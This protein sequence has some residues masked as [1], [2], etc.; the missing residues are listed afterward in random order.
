MSDV[1][2]SLDHCIDSYFSPRL[3]LFKSLL[4]ERVIDALLHMPSY[5]IEKYYLTELS[6][7][8]IN[9]IVTINFT[10]DCVEL[11][12]SRTTLPAQIYGRCG[13]QCVEIV[14]FNYKKSYVKSIYPIGK[15]VCISGKLQVSGRGIFKFVNPEKV[16]ISRMNNF[17]GIFNIYP[18]SNGISQ[19]NIHSVMKSALKILEQH[20]LIEWLPW[21]VMNQNAFSSF[22]DS[23]KNIHFPTEIYNHNIENPFYKRLV[24]DELLSEQLVLRLTSSKSKLGNIIKND[25]TLINELR[26]QLPFSLTNAQENALRE[27]LLDM[28]KEHPMTRLLQGDVGSGKTIVAIMAILYAIE[29]GYQCAVLA[30]T[31]ILARQHY[32]NIKK[33]FD[34]L[35]L[36]VDILT[37]SEKGKIRTQILNNVKLG[38]TNVLVGTHAI[39]TDKVTFFNLGLVVIDEQHRFGVN[40]RLDLIKKGRSPHVLSMTATPIPRT[41][42]MSLYGDIE[43][44]A[45][46][47]K[48]KGRKEIITRTISKSRI[49]DIIDSI[50]N[51]IQ[52]DQRVYWICPLVE[53]SEKLKYTCVVNRFEYLK[54][55]FPEN[56]LML[57]GKMKSK[58]KQEIFSKFQT[59]ECKILVSTTV[60]EVGVDVP[61][62]TTIIIENAE[63]FGLAQLHQLRGRV[64]RSDLQSY[65]ILLFEDKISKIATERLKIIRNSNDGFEIAEK[66]LQL[67]GGGEIIGVRQSGEKVYKTFD[68]KD[69]AIQS[70]LYQLLKQASALATYVIDHNQ[71]SNFKTL[72]KI[73][74]PNDF[75]NIKLSF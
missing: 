45:I 13:A 17:K 28:E 4:G 64:G 20:Q 11:N 46:T 12:Q 21:D 30:P 74:K 52:N 34:N 32:H 16:V 54:K 62:A 58:E 48:P 66:D 26:V 75:E 42:I 14:L 23:L 68:I 43:V 70:E 72:I 69:P 3:K 5:T 18:L 1:F 40:Q 56:V 55:Y 47:E 53:E 44:S 61:E 25:R 31:E 63:K 2:E 24:F 33:Y 59:G 15:Q 22:Y 67:R 9:Q 65:C 7:E 29:S 6:N 27:I 57:H 60:I 49:S 37:S 35:G 10:V 36:E 73:F 50:N 19:Y 38:N 71:I 39:I 51:I 41:I 8:Y